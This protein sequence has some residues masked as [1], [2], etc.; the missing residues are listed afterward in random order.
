MNDLELYQNL[1]DKINEI[2]AD[3]AEIRADLRAIKVDVEHHVY[4]SDMLEAEVKALDKSTTKLYGFFSISG[5]IIGVV[6][7]VLTI[8][9]KLGL[10]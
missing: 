8:M 4:R 1:T 7:T 3:V 9:T 2:A 6:A 5:W 10:M